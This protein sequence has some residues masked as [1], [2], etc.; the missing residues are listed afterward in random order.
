MAKLLVR[1]AHITAHDFVTAFFIDADDV[2]TLPIVHAVQKVVALGV[3]LVV[4]DKFAVV[5]V[6]CSLGWPGEDTVS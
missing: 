2:G 6:L 4:V 3:V 1:V 5:C